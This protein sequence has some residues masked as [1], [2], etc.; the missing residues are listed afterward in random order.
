MLITSPASTFSF[1][2]WSIIFEPRSYTVSMSVV[3]SVRRP[4]FV[5]WSQLLSAHESRC[6][7]PVTLLSTWISTTSPSINSV[8]SLI[9]TPILRRNAC[10][11]LSVLDICH[12]LKST[13]DESS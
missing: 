10:V 3:L 6:L 11:K 4:V 8:S 1:C 12:E 9:R 5:D 7:T 2:S 13:K